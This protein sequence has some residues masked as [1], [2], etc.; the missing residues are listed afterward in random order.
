MPRRVEALSW[1]I[2]LAM[3]ATACFPETE[4][5]QLTIY[6]PYVGAEADLFGEVLASFEE[7]TGI[8]VSYVGSSA[9]QADFAERVTTVDLPDITVLPQVAL[10][11]PLL[12]DDLVVGMDDET[13]ADISETVGP[14]WTALVSIGGEIY[15]VPYRF[16]VKSLVW[17]R[18]DV[19]AEKDYAVP[20]TMAQLKAL[21]R[22]M[23]D[24]GYTPWCAGMDSAG[25]TG[26][27]ATDWVE[28]LVAR[29]SPDRY[30]SWT[31][32]E[33]PFTDGNIVAAMREFQ[34]ML[35]S[36][37]AAA[38][39][40]RAILNVRVEDAI[41][42]MFDDEPG[43][44][45]HKQASFQP[46]W[47]PPD[48]TFEDEELDIFALP[49]VEA[50][51]PPMVMSGEIIVAT[52]ENPL[53]AEFLRY[54][55]N[56]E[57]FEPWRSVGG[58]LVARAE[59][60]DGGIPNSLDEKLE[61]MVAEAPAVYYDASDA[62]PNEIGSEAFFAGMIDLVAGNSASEVARSLQDRVDALNLD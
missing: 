5:E 8:S 35:T 33:T 17:Y 26:W 51:P 7:D 9:F 19:F 20:E 41:T 46:V 40:R 47:L 49:G 45:M 24:D 22:T 44:L 61:T 21:A 39:G 4:A 18:A 13:S 55:L 6:G 12:E 1:L 62:M 52:S 54:L 38:G 37:G 56:D 57:A 30:Y 29:R 10:L 60:S 25:S 3:V 58:S 53:N 27:W 48:V 59:P 50:D 42:P 31:G 11:A 36:D 14:Q 34:E 15:G 16:V 28:D 43:C 2:G 23:I 32:L